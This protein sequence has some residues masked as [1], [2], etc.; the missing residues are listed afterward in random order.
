ME[1]PCDTTTTSSTGNTSNSAE[2]STNIM[3]IIDAVGDNDN[4]DNN[5]DDNSAEVDEADDNNVEKPLINA[6][7]KSNYNNNN[8]NNDNKVTVNEGE[9][10]NMKIWTA[11]SLCQLVYPPSYDTVIP[12]QS[13]PA[14]QLRVN[15]PIVKKLKVGLTSETTT[16][17]VLESE[18]TLTCYDCAVLDDAT[19]MFFECKTA[20]KHLAGYTYE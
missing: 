7:N 8:N 16:S 11:S 5:D 12:D 15:N 17:T 9:Y 19:K 13:V 2:S 18:S 14:L 1:K 4:N 6:T 3:D 20:K 10:V